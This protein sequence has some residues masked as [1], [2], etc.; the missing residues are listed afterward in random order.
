MQ[1]N[2]RHHDQLE[3][4]LLLVSIFSFFGDPVLLFFDFLTFELETRTSI[5]SDCFEEYITSMAEKVDV[6]VKK[7]II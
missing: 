2:Y 7:H 5:L 4:V 6:N 1:H 3:L